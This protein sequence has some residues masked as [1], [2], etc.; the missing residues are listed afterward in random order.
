MRWSELREAYAVK[1][2]RS[3]PPTISPNSDRVMLG[4]FSRR[5]VASPKALLSSSSSRGPLSSSSPPLYLL[6]SPPPS[7]QLL[8]KKHFALNSGFGLSPGKWDQVAIAAKV[9]HISSGK[10]LCLAAVHLKSNHGGDYEAV[11]VAQ[12]AILVREL[13]AFCPKYGLL[14]L[15]RWHSSKALI[16]EPLLLCGDFNSEPTNKVYSLFTAE[17][18]STMAGEVRSCSPLISDLNSSGQRAHNADLEKSSPSPERLC[19]APRR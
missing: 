13:A 1:V 9:K 15:F 19:A 12:A 4:T 8:T 14:P 2:A 18:V 16:R 5:T 6:L 11:R 7:F 10:E 17:E 3:L